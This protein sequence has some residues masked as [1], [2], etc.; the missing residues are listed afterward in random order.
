[1]FVQA[2]I[3]DF[4]HIFV[5]QNKKRLR[6]F[7]YWV[8]P[9]T[10]QS[11]LHNSEKYIANGKF[12]DCTRCACVCVHNFHLLWVLS[13]RMRTRSTYLCGRCRHRPSRLRRFVKVN[14]FRF[15]NWDVLRYFIGQM[16]IMC[17]RRVQLIKWVKWTYFFI[18]PT[19]FEE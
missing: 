5:I 9:P 2:A 14:Y 15:E 11:T 18:V 8:T 13:H 6:D 7:K 17:L 4:G 1:M 12:S 19:L 16:G 10:V 3:D